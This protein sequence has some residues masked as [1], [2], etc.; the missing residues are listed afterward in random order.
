MADAVVPKA[1]EG[2][3]SSTTERLARLCRLATESV[4]QAAEEIG[5]IF[6]P[7]SSRRFPDGPRRGPIRNLEMIELADRDSGFARL[8]GAPE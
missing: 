1:G 3:T 6:C 4:D 5:R 7:I 8:S 2:R